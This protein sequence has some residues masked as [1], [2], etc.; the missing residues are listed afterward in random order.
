MSTPCP[1]SRLHSP[2]RSPDSPPEL[3]PGL[4]SDE[5]S[6]PPFPVDLIPYPPTPNQHPESIGVSSVSSHASTVCLVPTSP[7]ANQCPAKCNPAD[8]PN[9]CLPHLFRPLAVEK[10]LSGHSKASS[11]PP[12]SKLP[13]PSSLPP[14]MIAKRRRYDTAMVETSRRYTLTVLAEQK[15]SGAL[16]KVSDTK[17]RKR[18]L[19]KRSA[20]TKEGWNGRAGKNERTL[21]HSPTFSGEIWGVFWPMLGQSCIAQQQERD[22]RNES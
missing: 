15:N 13:T 17:W 1:H 9:L 12:S 8:Y 7:L 11:P 6:P 16:E 14:W 19:V 5:D 21:G 20:E 18:E 22:H 4:W 2:P 10:M 3:Y